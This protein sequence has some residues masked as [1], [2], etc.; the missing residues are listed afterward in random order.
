MKIYYLVLVLTMSTNISFGQK[1]IAIDTVTNRT[2]KIKIGK[3]VGLETKKEIINPEDYHDSTMADG[4]SYYR[5]D[6]YWKL[7][8]IDTSKRSLSLLNKVSGTT[9]DFRFSEIKY[10]NYRRDNDSRYRESLFFIGLGV[11][12]GGVVN[13]VSKDGSKSLGYGLL[14]VGL[15]INVFIFGTRSW[16]ELRKYKI[17]GTEN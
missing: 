12:I 7:H 2:Q 1:I 13:V 5:P 16:T 9:R 14:A 4:L 10:L 8:S 11:T 15:S 6:G 17:K 3:S